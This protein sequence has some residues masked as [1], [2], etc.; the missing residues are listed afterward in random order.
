MRLGVDRPELGVLKRPLKNSG[1]LK[2]VGEGEGVLLVD[3]EC[4]IA[5]CR[6]GDG[7]RVEDE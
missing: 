6:G 2:V 4:F 1:I 7:A 3:S 5:E